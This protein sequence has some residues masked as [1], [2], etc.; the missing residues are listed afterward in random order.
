MAPGTFGYPLCLAAFFAALGL[1]VRSNSEAPLAPTAE[2]AA[3][4][5]PG[6]YVSPATL[7]RLFNEADTAFAAKEYV[8]AVAKIQ[9][10]LKALGTNK[11]ARLEMLYFNIGLGNLLYGNSAEAEK[12]FTECLKRFPK[13]E[14]ASRCHLGMARACIMQG[15]PENLE[16]A[17]D[18]LILAALDPKNRTEAGILLGQVNVDL[19]KRDEAML[20]F[21]S[22]MGSDIHSPAQTSAAIEVMSLLADNDKLEDLILFLERLINQSGVRKA[23]IWHANQVIARGDQLVNEKRYDAAL[24]LY[25]SIPPRAQILEVQKIALDSQRKD[26]K[27]LEARVAAEQDVALNKPSNASEL[28]AIMKPAVE[29]A[30]KALAGVEERTDLDAAIL[31]RRGRCL[32]NLDRDEE[33]LVCLRVIR[34][35][36]GSTPDAKWAAYG[37]III[38][39]KLK[40]FSQMKV[41]CD[42]FLQKYPDH[43]NAEQVA[44]LAGEVLVQN[45]EWKEVGKFYKDLEAKYPQSASLDRFT[46]FQAL[47]FFMEADFKESIPLFT[48][49]LKNFP[50]NALTERAL[51]YLA[52]SHFLSDNYK[53]TLKGC[54]EY[55][56][57]FPD[58][59]YAGD[60]LHRL[61]FVDFNDKGPGKDPKA[62]AI[63]ENSMCDKIIRDLTVFINQHP[64]D[65][66]VGSMWC[67]VAESYKKKTSAN[68]DEL[69]RFQQLALDA[70]KKAALS[71]SPDDVIQ[72]GLDCATA[73]L[74]EQ[75]EWAQIA[76][77]HSEF[78]KKKP[79]SALALT[80]IVW[81]IK[82]L[83]REG[84]SVEA[85]DIVANALKLKMGDP[86]NEQVE[87]L[88]DEL[89]KALVLRKKPSEVDIDAVDKQLVEIL[90]KVIAGKENAT[91]HARILYA[92][93]RLAQALKR[94]DHADL[95]LKWVATTHAKDP[96]VLSSPLLAVSGDILLKLGQLDEAQTMFQRLIDRHKGGMNADAG[97][98]GL[99]YIALAR[100]KPEEA[101]KIFDNYLKNNPGMARFKEATLG[102]LEAL[103]EL[104]QLEKAEKLAIKTIDDR[105]FRW[106][107]AGKANLLLARIYRKQ[108]EK[109]EGVAE[110]MELLKKCFAICQ[111]VYISSGNF[112]EV[113]AEG[114]WQA[115]LT[116][117]DLGKKET[118]DNT[119]KELLAHPKLQ[120][121]EA[122]KRAAA[123]GK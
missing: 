4:A 108:S 109:A 59:D 43:Q 91:T 45:G 83:S 121:T 55:L 14:Y 105:A 68:A 80:S 22:L 119:L 21:K 61:A 11:H 53:E 65:A 35:K 72:Y 81:I 34:M 18:A 3:P 95:Y 122:Y 40:D 8:K 86:A 17:I 63:Y 73:M 10:L 92:R 104:G 101:L 2:Q 69:A 66:A 115:Y 1:F 67:L 87:Y 44:I 19:G 94:N 102:K 112:P 13:G 78:I 50:D 49:F 42:A 46:F 38:L 98:V 117:I 111:R 6:D 52:M 106:E 36:Y 5:I 85:A 16:R 71:D 97:T 57:R 64:Q 9:E 120:N 116:A 107:A 31:M 84:K 15:D 118:A 54:K 12:G 123:N 100:K 23:F 58:G 77:M 60:M 79:D 20:I 74:Q 110:K 56:N 70:Y 33:A 24:A 96:S 47:S 75:K 28:L 29:L 76:A 37:E 103:I 114:Y 39:N 51:Y 27:I 41:L 99:G 113:C 88:I 7:T 30:A 32:Y 82:G 48:K 89:V 93:A 25:R 62:I 26:V 90:N